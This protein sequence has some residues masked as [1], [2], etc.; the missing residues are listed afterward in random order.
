M[1]KSGEKKKGKH[2]LR[3]CTANS[4]HQEHPRQEGIDNG[5]G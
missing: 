4:C 2:N 3:A 1:N 5:A